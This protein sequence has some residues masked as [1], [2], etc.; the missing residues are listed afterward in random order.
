MA[1]K[2]IRVLVVEDHHVVRKSLVTLL[3]T[4]A[5]FE[6]VG[7]AG[8]GLEAIAQFH[9]CQPDVT[10]IDLRLPRK[11]GPE[12]VRSIRRESKHARFIVLTTY[13]GEE[14][15]YRALRAGAQSYLL[16]GITSDELVTA[17]RVVHEGRSHLPPEIFAKLAARLEWEDITPRETEVLEHIVQGRSNRGIAQLLGIS[18]ATVKAHI[19]NL[20]GKLGVS[21]RTHAATT[22][23]Q[24]GIVAL[25]F[26]RNVNSDQDGGPITSAPADLLGSE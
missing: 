16:K 3:E 21:D 22:A 9:R 23:I 14:D 4:I 7:E 17:I 5:G 6:V 10:L 24:R 13:D 2:L 19:N 20:L 18:E 1:E 12:V 11:S 25:D 26:F 15:V 8:D